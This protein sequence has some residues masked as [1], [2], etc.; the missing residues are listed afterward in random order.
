[1][2]VCP[3]CWGVKVYSVFSENLPEGQYEGYYCIRCA[4]TFTKDDIPKRF[5]IW[6]IS[7]NDSP[8]Y[9]EYCGAVVVATSKKEA[10]DQCGYRW[11]GTE[12]S[13]FEPW[14][15]FRE[16]NVTIVELKGEDYSE[17][18]IILV[19]FNAG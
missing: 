1:M 18:D 7:R 13:F 2:I 14:E 4:H 3:K 10:L 9:D 6:Y 17:P 12:D 5:K 8:D 11:E 16:D 19:D 15:G